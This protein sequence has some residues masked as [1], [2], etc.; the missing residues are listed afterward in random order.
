MKELTDELIEYLDQEA[1]IEIESAGELTDLGKQLRRMEVTAKRL[2]REREGAALRG[3]G[4]T[5]DISKIPP[6]CDYTAARMDNGETHGANVGQAFGW[7]DSVQAALDDAIR[8]YRREYLWDEIVE[9]IRGTCNSIGSALETFNA[10]DLEDDTEFLGH[11]DQEIFLCDTCGWWCET[12]EMAE[13]EDETGQVC[14]DCSE[15]EEN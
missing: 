9:H 5:L 10:G 3:D 12:S 15:Q 6:G 4:Q 14:T 11:L 13:D 8:A 7:G 1:Q 2:V